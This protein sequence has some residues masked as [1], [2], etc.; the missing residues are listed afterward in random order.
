MAMLTHCQ[1]LTH[2]CGYSEG[3]T[4][5][6]SHSH[7]HS[8]IHSERNAPFSYTLVYLGIYLYEKQKLFC[9]CLCVCVFSAETLVN[10]LDFKKDVGL[11]HGVLTV[12]ILLHSYKSVILCILFCIPFG[13]SILLSMFQS[14]LNMLHTV[15]VPYALMK[16]NPLSWVQKVCQYKG[17][18]RFVPPEYYWLC[19]ILL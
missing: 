13:H 6:C 19:V 3:K 2:T 12:I 18:K 10:V 7:S 8:I 11:W 1:T 17:T 14:V 9:V 15:S 4:C 5:T 16:V